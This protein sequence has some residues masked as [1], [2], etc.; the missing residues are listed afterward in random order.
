QSRGDVGGGRNRNE[1][2]KRGE[3]AAQ[4]W[5]QKITIQMSRWQTGEWECVRCELE[6]TVRQEAGITEVE[7][8]DMDV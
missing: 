4:E 6:W 7:D 1:E 3:A 8:R 5:L 2:G